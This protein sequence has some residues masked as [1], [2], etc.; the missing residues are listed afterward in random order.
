MK[1]SM[2][3]G[4][5]YTFTF[6][7]DVDGV[8]QTTVC[9]YAYFSVKK[10]YTDRDVIFQKKLSD[11]SILFDGAGTYTVMILPEDTED[12]EFGVYEFDVEVVKTDSYKRTFT[13]TLE[14]TREITHRN[15]EDGGEVPP[16]PPYAR[17]RSF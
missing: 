17:G 13:G 7:V 5:L 4:D 14:L 1:I 8:E 11:G 15:N 16:G 2:A 6:G 12:L 3:R 10:R 9:D